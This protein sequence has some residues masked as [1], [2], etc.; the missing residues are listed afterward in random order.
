MDYDKVSPA[1]WGRPFRR[2]NRVCLKCWTHWF[3]PVS[4]VVM[5]TRQQWDDL[6]KDVLP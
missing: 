3:G 1:N 5:Y 4:S 6:M 2:I